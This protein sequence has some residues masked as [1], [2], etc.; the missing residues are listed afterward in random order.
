MSAP[1]VNQQMMDLFTALGG[2]SNLTVLLGAGASAPSGLPNWDDF[3][4]S[5]TLESGLISDRDAARTL[6]KLQDPTIV[7]EAARS[8]SSTDWHDLLVRCLYGSP[9]TH[10][11]PSPLH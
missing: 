2:E 6:L 3:A 10:A 1:D 4:L 5:A 9:P 11:N 7:L 8:H